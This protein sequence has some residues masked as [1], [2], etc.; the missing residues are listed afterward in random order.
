MGSKIEFGPGTLYMTDE[1]GVKRPLGDINTIDFVEDMP[2]YDIPIKRY[3]GDYTFN[4]TVN[5]TF[6]GKVKLFGF[7]NTIRAMIR[8]AFKRGG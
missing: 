3:D 1:D 6:R 4:A 8:S 7:W 5:L 2:K